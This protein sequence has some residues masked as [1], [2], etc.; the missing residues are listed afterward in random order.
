MI[1]YRYVWKNNPK[2]VSL[3]D[4]RCYVVRRLKFNSAV[5]EFE[6]GQREIISRSALRKLKGEDDA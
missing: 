6:D 5:V 2:R 3:Y 4:R 1:K